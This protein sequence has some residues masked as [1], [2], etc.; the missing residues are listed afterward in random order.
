[1]RNSPPN[2]RLKPRLSDK[3]GKVAATKTTAR[4]KHS[5]KSLPI[6]LAISPK[7][8]A[9][10]NEWSGDTEARI[11]QAARQ[12][13]LNRGLSGARMR[14]I[15]A[16]AG[17]NAALPNY[18]FRSKEALYAAALRDTLQKVWGE[19]K[20]AALSLS[21]DA[22]FEELIREFLARYF[23]LLTQHPEFPRL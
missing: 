3:V 23:A 2:K 13:F 9:Q 20:Q 21:P 12:E 22:S 8:K 11:L 10:S 18:Y 14:S 17:V 15:A 19:L 16:S 4:T 5:P 1:M 6:K 7:N